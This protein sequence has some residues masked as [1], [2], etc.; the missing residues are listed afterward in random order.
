MPLDNFPLPMYESI[1]SHGPDFIPPTHVPQREF[2]RWV[3]QGGEVHPLMQTHP[4]T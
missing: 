1:L 4:V 2:S 3:G